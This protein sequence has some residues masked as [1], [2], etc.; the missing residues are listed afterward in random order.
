MPTSAAHT[1]EP[2][3]PSSAPAASKKPR[4]EMT[5]GG[6]NLP[7]NFV[8]QMQRRTLGARD[9]S[10][11]GMTSGAATPR[12]PSGTAT[13]GATTTSGAGSHAATPR[14]T[15]GAPR[16]TTRQR[17]TTTA[18]DLSAPIA[19]QDLLGLGDGGS[20]SSEQTMSR[21]TRCCNRAHQRCQT[22][23][24]WTSCCSCVP[25]ST[26]LSL[27]S[28]A[29]MKKL[30][31][32]QSQLLT[33]TDKGEIEMSEVREDIDGLVQRADNHH[34]RLRAL[35][36]AVENASLQ[37]LEGARD[38]VCAADEQPNLAYAMSELE[39]GA[40]ATAEE[41]R[42]SSFFVSVASLD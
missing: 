21:A 14:A 11:G 5:K 12:A 34:G 20:A 42:S 25:P 15:A 28:P 9:D 33:N 18:G 29:C 17:A 24:L 27:R 37:F 39:A 16:T 4:G 38:G 19:N 32:G 35:E 8:T 22:D 6:F 26:V 40:N 1:H 31:G 23:A 3:S 10:P 13:P 41:L 7:T 36:D 2:P 30:Q